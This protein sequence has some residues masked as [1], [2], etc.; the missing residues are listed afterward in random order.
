MDNP[1]RRSS[2]PLY[3]SALWLLGGAALCLAGCDVAPQSDRQP[4]PVRAQ[5]V[6]RASRAASGTLTGEVKA[7][8]QSDL[9]FRFSGR[10]ASRAVDVGDHVDA[11]Q[12]LAT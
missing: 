12:V 11:G 5:A 7:R 9:A 8:V 10:I 1:R 4:S 3:G 6:T 2:H